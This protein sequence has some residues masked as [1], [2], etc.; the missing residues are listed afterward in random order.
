MA[1]TYLALEHDLEIIPIINKIDLPSADPNEAKREIEE[2]IGL[3]VENA[4]TVSAKMGQG[5]QEVL[6]VAAQ[7]IP[8]PEG[9]SELP[10]VP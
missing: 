3:D 6:E 4:I 7:R 1:N 2:I 10:C 8:P 9:L 5:I